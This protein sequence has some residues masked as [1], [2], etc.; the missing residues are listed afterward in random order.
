MKID[1]KKLAC[2]MIDAGMNNKQLSEASNV[3]V[4]RISNIKNGNNTTYETVSKIAKALRVP[5]Q[6][7]IEDNS[8]EV[9]SEPDQN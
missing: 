2:S 8:E 7:L 4:A 5:V 3:S 9:F 1:K 6:D